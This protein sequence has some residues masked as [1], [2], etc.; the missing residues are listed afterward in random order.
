MKLPSWLKPKPQVAV[1]RQITVV[2]SSSLRLSDWTCDESLV[3]E[4]N[5]LQQ[6]PLFQA[7][8]GVLRNESPGCYGVAMG[9]T[10]DDRIAHACKAEGYQLALNNLEALGVLIK[11]Q[12][13]L[14]STF[15]PETASKL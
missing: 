2:R 3:K 4:T 7:M 11:P 12:A 14:E 15:E 9:A 10:H 1:T 5:K 8:L 13:F 6:T